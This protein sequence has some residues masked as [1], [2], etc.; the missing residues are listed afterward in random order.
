VE[1]KKLFC[2]QLGAP[3]KVL[4][5]MTVAT[6]FGDRDIARD[7]FRDPEANFRTV[8]PAV[9]IE[10]ILNDSTEVTVVCK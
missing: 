5:T 8:A 7:M 9:S 10:V 6:A 4:C 1:S 2:R 3:V